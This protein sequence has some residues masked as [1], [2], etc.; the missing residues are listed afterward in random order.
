[1]ATQV[2]HIKHIQGLPFQVTV[3]GFAF[4]SSRPSLL[5][6]HICILTH[7]HSDHTTGLYKSFQGEILCTQITADL[8][9]NIIGIDSRYVR[10]LELRRTYNFDGLEITAIDA[11]HCPGA[12]IFLLKNTFTGKER[13][14]KH[15]LPSFPLCHNQLGYTVLHTGDFRAALHLQADEFLLTQRID[16]IYLDTTY[17][18]PKYVFAEQ[19]EVLN[20]VEEI[21]K[22][23][24][25]EEP[26]TCFVVGTYQIGKE[27]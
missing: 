5:G 10:T 26:T 16:T 12:A 17:C 11:F 22:R 23:E 24:L 9:V 25:E 21:T 13:E 15:S 20:M 3:D 19:S 2:D 1:M 18:A 27:K 14:S 4:V 7:F 6:R 8:I